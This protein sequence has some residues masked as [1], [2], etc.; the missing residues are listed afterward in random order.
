MSADW[1]VLLMAYGTPRTLEEVEP[2]YTHIRR[3]RPPSPEQLQDLVRRYEAIGGVSPLNEITLQQARAV[4]AKLRARGWTGRLYLGMKHWHPFIAEAVEQMAREG[5]ERAV[6][7]VLAPHYSRYSIGGYIDYALKAREQFAPQMELRFV[8]RWG[9]H[10]LFIEAVARRIQ[11]AL[12]GWNPEE[13]V[14]LFS[15]HSL[16]EKVRQWNDPYEQEL[17][18]SARLVAEKLELPHWTFAFQS[19]SATG[20][21]WLG[22]DILERLEEIAAAGEYKQVLCYAIGFVADHLEV[23]YDLDVEARQKCQERGLQYR[24]AASLNDDPLM[25]EA[26]ADVTWKRM[27]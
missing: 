25:A 21:P 23:L 19:A 2:Y 11:Q 10:P 1:D 18:E 14:V 27:E 12:E 17:L 16:P 7:V 24:R 13:T 20:E 15:A 8:E 6:G 5:V 26:V 9:S 22:P 4:E 3:G